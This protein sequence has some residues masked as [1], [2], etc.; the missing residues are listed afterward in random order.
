MDSSG[1]SRILSEFDRI[2]AYSFGFFRIFPNS[3]RVSQNFIE[4]CHTIII[5][6]DYFLVFFRIFSDSFRFYRLVS[7][8]FGFSLILSEFDRI[9]SYSFGFFRMLPNYYSGLFCRILSDSVQFF[10]F[11]GFFQVFQ[12]CLTFSWILMD[13]YR[14]FWIFSYPFR[15]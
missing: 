9:L 4:F 10:G 6:P 13:F 12:V 3:L 2:L 1:F 15:I 8:F 5:W 7:H 14:F 11:L